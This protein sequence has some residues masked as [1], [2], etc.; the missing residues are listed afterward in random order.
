MTSKLIKI[1]IT[2]REQLK[3]LTNLSRSTQ[4]L[5][6]KP[7]SRKLE[8]SLR[9]DATFCSNSSEVESHGT[10]RTSLPTLIATT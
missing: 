5:T 3:N 2:N 1:M 6:L 8:T 10:S 7:S 9:R 4:I